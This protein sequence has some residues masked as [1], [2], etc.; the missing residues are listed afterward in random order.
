MKEKIFAIFVGLFSLGYL[1]NVGAGVFELFPDNFPIV[2]NIDEGAAGA[3]L[4]WAI[5][6]L[7][8]RQGNTL[9]RAQVDER[10]DRP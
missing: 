7:R 6:V 1:L 8:R 4:L 5:H 9:K 2:G 10:A 3:A